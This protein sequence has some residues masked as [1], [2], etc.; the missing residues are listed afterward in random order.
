M[1]LGA[2]LSN[3]LSGLS[4]ATKSTELISSNISNAL[5][6]NYGKRSLAVSTRLGDHGGVT[7][8]AI[9]RDE[10]KALVASLRMSTAQLNSDQTRADFSAALGRLIGETTSEYSLGSDFNAF[11][12]AM[13][14][15]AG[16]PHDAQRVS[17]AVSAADRVATKISTAAKGIED[18]RVQMK[19]SIGQSL[20]S[21]NKTLQSLQR[22]NA[23]IA[24]S[25][26]KTGQMAGLLDQR[27]QLL[28]ELAAN[29]EFK[30]YHRENGQIALYTPEGAR[31]LEGSASV[32]ST[33][34]DTATGE[35]SFL[36]NGDRETR[37]GAIRGHILCLMGLRHGHRRPLPF[38]Q[39]FRSTRPRPILP[40]WSKALKYPLR[41]A[42][43]CRSQSN[44]VSLPTVKIRLFPLL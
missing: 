44:L 41:C 24:G 32:I 29:V 27:N 8:D 1:S 30:I 4:F 38:S 36:I 10:N 34:Q 23:S 17:R 7:I 16:M 11:R 12:N 42:Q 43:C 15:A 21:T 31:L 22:L 20:N 25:S 14:E 2:A 19:K 28:N 39:R 40:P 9:R 18:L 5:S 6:P 13:I 37:F 35:I 26:K 3:A 33:A